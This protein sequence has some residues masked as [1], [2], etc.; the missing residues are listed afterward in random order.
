MRTTPTPYTLLP[1]ATTILLGGCYA[2]LGARI[3]APLSDT[4]VGVT[5]GPELDLGLL[6]DFGDSQI[7]AGGRLGGIG[8]GED[9]LVGGFA[10][11][12]L[13]QAPPMSNRFGWN[14]RVAFSYASL[15]PDDSD[16][17]LPGT[18]V[19]IMI[20]PN[21]SGISRDPGEGQQW[22]RGGGATGIVVS[23][24]NLSEETTWNIGFSL[25]ITSWLDTKYLESR[26]NK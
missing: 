20:G 21:F 8:V 9:H 23:R 7:F 2:A 25:K 18:L 24:L 4:S 26:N 17:E 3:Q 15:I 5:A 14:W 22:L 12:M 10:G 13:E 1:I 16:L 19:S 6:A 11:F